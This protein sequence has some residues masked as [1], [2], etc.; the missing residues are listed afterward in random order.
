M[1]VWSV[2]DCVCGFPFLS[3][4]GMHHLLGDYSGGGS[5]ATIFQFSR[6]LAPH[7]RIATAH[8]DAVITA[9]TLG[10]RDRKKR[11]RERE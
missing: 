7:T 4:L 5:V 11:Q 9:R 3:L 1:S 2:F 8:C 10:E 6:H